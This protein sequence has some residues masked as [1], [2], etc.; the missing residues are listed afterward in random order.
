MSLHRLLGFRTSVPDPD[1]LVR[2]FGDLGL[3]AGANGW[4]GSDGGGAVSVTEGPFRRLESIAIGCA[5]DADVHAIARRLAEGGAEATIDG[6]SV[7][8]RDPASR[9]AFTVTPAAPEAQP[10]PPMLVTPN[11]PGATE[12]ADARAPALAGRA[13]P[14]RR[15]GHVVIG[16]PDPGASRRLLVDGLGFKVSDER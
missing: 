4:T 15:L 5:D 3:I 1:G 12:R 14:P 8:V 6:G 2:F 11:A 7:T 10:A 16:T 13:R 9:V